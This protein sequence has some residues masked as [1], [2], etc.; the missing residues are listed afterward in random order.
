[1]VSRGD[2]IT[3]TLHGEGMTLR[4]RVTPS[5]QEYT[6]NTGS[7]HVHR[8]CTFDM[9]QWTRFTIYDSDDDS[10]DALS[11]SDDEGEEVELHTTLLC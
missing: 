10:D 6:P 8:D 2:P 3:T 4:P 1:M 7:D 11:E 9:D 5:G